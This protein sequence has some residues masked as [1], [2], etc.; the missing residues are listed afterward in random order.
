MFRLRGPY[1]IFQENVFQTNVFQTNVLRVNVFPVKFLPG[2]FS[3]QLISYREM[4]HKEISPGKYHSR[5]KP[6]FKLSSSPNFSILNKYPILSV[7]WFSKLHG[8][9]LSIKKNYN[10]PDDHEE[11][12]TTLKLHLFMV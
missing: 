11:K 12:K 1:P 3:R 6:Y 4:F 8:K 5:K 2:K 9:K 7:F 10:L